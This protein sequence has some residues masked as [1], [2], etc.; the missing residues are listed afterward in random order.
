MFWAVLVIIGSF[1]RGPGQNFIFP[2]NGER[3]FFDL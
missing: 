3:I 2:W 1:F